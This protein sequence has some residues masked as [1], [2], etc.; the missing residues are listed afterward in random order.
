[1]KVFP[2]S[3]LV[4]SQLLSCGSWD[5]MSAS[6]RGC[7]VSSLGFRGATSRALQ[8]SAYHL[9]GAACVE[10]VPF[11][12]DHAMLRRMADNHDFSVRS[13]GSSICTPDRVPVDLL[14]KLS[15]YA[16]DWYVE[17]PPNAAMA[18]SM[19]AVLSIFFLRLRSR[20]PEERAHAARSL[21]EIAKREPEILDPDEIRTELSS[22]KAL[23]D[24]KAAAS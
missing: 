19:P 3:G 11:L 12:I 6:V 21:A 1:M 14:I 17:T 16:E 13:S 5:G 22:L 15:D 8:I 10:F 18:R 24:K 23:G 2:E 20:D 7:S 4:L 9:P